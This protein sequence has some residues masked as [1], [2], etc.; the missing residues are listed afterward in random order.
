MKDIQLA[1]IQGGEAQ[2][3]E[4]TC[5]RSHVFGQLSTNDL[6]VLDFLEVVI[7]SGAQGNR[8]RCRGIWVAS[9]FVIAKVPSSVLTVKS[10]IFTTVA[11]PC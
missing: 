1:T 9:P 5:L 2:P 11:L 6:C 3:R 10:S 7:N 4:V 8:G